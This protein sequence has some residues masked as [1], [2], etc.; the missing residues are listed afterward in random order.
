MEKGDRRVSVRVR[1]GDMRVE[2]ENQRDSCLGET[3]PGV[4]GFEDGGRDHGP[5]NEG[6]L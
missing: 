3:L 6:S 2:A 1:K 4:A 5:R